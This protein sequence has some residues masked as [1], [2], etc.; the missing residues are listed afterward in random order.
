MSEQN[1]PD[2]GEGWRLLKVNE[3]IEPGDQILDKVHGWTQTLCAGD[4]VNTGKYR[5]RIPDT[6]QPATHHGGD[7]YRQ[8]GIECIDAIRAALTDEEFRGFCKGNVI[9]YAWRERHKGGDADLKKC[10]DYLNYVEAI[11]TE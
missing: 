4:Y 5:R 2:P 7:H 8:G 10:G 1:I 11:K 9:K 3:R 6:P